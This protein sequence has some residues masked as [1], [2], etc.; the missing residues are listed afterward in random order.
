MLDTDIL[1]ELALHCELAERG[2]L[3]NE[4]HSAVTKEGNNATING[5]LSPA[6]IGADP[7]EHRTPATNPKLNMPQ[8]WVAWSGDG[9]ESGA[10]EGT[11]DMGIQDPAQSDGAD[12]N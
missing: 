4:L 5:T 3:E 2:V 12:G 11:A 6:V 1:I 10:E 7:T 8:T 9:D